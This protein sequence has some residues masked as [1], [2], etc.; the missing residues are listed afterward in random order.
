MAKKFLLFVLVL[1]IV[2]AC[3]NGGKDDTIEGPLEDDSISRIEIDPEKINSLIESFPS[4]IEMAAT[5]EDMQVPY[6]K[7]NLVPT[8][9]AGDFDSNFE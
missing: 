9:L 1:A 6:S 8:E 4:P 3:G 2:S 7:K 5:I